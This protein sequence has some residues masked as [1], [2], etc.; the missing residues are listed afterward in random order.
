MAA[1]ECAGNGSERKSMGRSDRNDSLVGKERSEAEVILTCT[2][3]STR[4]I[5]G[6]SVQNEMWRISQQARHMS[7]GVGKLK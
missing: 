6:K 7:S 5:V 3:G 4:K 1:E 2:K